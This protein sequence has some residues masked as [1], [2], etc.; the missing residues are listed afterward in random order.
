[1]IIELPRCEACER[2]G[3]WRED[4]QAYLCNPHAEEPEYV[5]EAEI[6]ALTD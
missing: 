6:V 2:L 3:K 5:R 1:M 4:F